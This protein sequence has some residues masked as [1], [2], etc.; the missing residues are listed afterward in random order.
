MQTF[1]SATLIDYAVLGN[2]KIEPLGSWCVP[3]SDLFPNSDYSSKLYTTGFVERRIVFQYIANLYDRIMPAFSSQMNSYHN[4]NFTDDQWE[5]ICGYWLL[6]VLNATF[7]RWQKIEDIAIKYSNLTLI[8]CE[9]SKDFNQRF[10]TMQDSRISYNHEFNSFLCEK[11][12]TYFDKIKI[13][14]S[15]LNYEEV[16]SGQEIIPKRK[17]KLLYFTTWKF[18]Q[19]KKLFFDNLIVRTGFFARQGLI[20]MTH[21]NS[22]RDLIWLMYRIKKPIFISHL[23]IPDNPSNTKVRDIALATFIANDEFEKFLKQNLMSFVPISVLSDFKLNIAKIQKAKWDFSPKLLISDTNHTGGNDLMRIWFG[24]YGNNKKQLNVVQHGGAY[25]EMELQWSLHFENRISNKFYCWG[26]AERKNNPLKFSNIPSLRLLKTRKK[27]MRSTDN[28]IVMLLFPEYN[29][30]F[31]P[32]HSQ[33]SNR[34]E[35][36]LNLEFLSSFITALN[37]KENLAVKPQNSNYTVTTEFI[38]KFHPNIYLGNVDIFKN[39][40]DCRVL[41]STYNGTNTLECF[42]SGIPTILIWDKRFFHPNEEAKKYLLNL[43]KAGVLYF[44]AV[45]AAEFLNLDHKFI[46]KWWLE[47]EVQEAVNEYLDHFGSTKGGSKEFSKII[48]TAWKSKN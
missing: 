38:K 31:L 25:G 12:A 9:R 13:V 28:L 6:C 33:P 7:F 46:D 45:A 5:N 10:H 16:L 14:K 4:T 40:Q 32:L 17:T 36:I 8:I 22:L 20:V 27:K 39:S 19:I 26:W 41:I 30:S 42:T 44:D 11:I 35:H 2:I 24:L 21:W 23:N 3:T 34:D 37:K 47:N 18:A 48:A 43:E 1:I 29:Y 15:K